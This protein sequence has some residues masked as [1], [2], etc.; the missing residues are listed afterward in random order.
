MMSERIMFGKMP[1]A[2]FFE[3]RFFDINRPYTLQYK[4][5]PEEDVARPHCSTSLEIF[6][7]ID[8]VGSFHLD[9]QITALNSEHCFVIPPFT[10]H[11]VNLK[12]GRGE[13]YVMQLSFTALRPYIDISQ[14]LH[15]SGRTIQPQVLPQE[16]IPFFL[17]EFQRM[18]KND[19]DM[20]LC[21]HSI[22]KILEKITSIDL[23]ADSETAKQK[24]SVYSEELQA[25]IVWSMNHFCQPI[26]LSTVAKYAG[27][28]KSYFCTWFKKNT[29][30]SYTD[31]INM[32][33]VNYSCEVL[34]KTASISLAC[35]SVGFHDV[36]YFIKLF[37]SIKGC[38]PGDYLRRK[39]R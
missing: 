29:G 4:T 35:E 38:T 24:H 25:V 31:Y 10:I 20:L 19:H 30:M 6:M 1:P 37:K 12:H 22:L 14:L 28:T 11:S 13:V 9:G 3:D 33:R 23:A 36:S 18:I 17:K 26:S 8:A 21:V 32:L 2:T 39:D 15:I 7:S 5:L 27:Y 16:D 34:G